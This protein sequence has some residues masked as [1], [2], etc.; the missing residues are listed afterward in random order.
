MIK[1][2]VLLSV[3]FR[4]I[5]TNAKGVLN[6]PFYTVFIRKAAKKAPL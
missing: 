5:Y 1:S 6:V 3:F 2:L 4:V